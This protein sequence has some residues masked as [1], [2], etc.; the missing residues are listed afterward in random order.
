MEPLFYE[1]IEYVQTR[2]ISVAAVVLFA[3]YAACKTVA[4][5]WRS[6]PLFLIVGLAGFALSQ[7]VMLSFA[8]EYLEKL[9]DFRILFDFLSAYVGSFVV[10]AIIHFIKPI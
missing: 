7:F 9:P 1:M 10:A 3:G 5:D 6:V 8:K 2:T 4:Y